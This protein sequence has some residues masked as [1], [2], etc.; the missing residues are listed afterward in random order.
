MGW[1][2]APLC[3]DGS[4]PFVDILNLDEDV[5]FGIAPRYEVLM[6]EDE[7]VELTNRSRRAKTG[8]RECLVTLLSAC[9]EYLPKLWSENNVDLT[10][11][12][13]LPTDY[14]HMQS[15]ISEPRLDIDLLAE[16]LPVLVRRKRPTST[17]LE[18]MRGRSCHQ[19]RKNICEH[20]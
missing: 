8:N 4:D 3:F 7:V 19:F 16:L 1:N 2:W 10:L 5:Q 11:Y 20:A 17:V 9:V 14:I 6:I 12:V 18:S 15:R 13:Q